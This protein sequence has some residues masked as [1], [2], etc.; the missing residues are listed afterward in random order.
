[1]LLSP[2]ALPLNNASFPGFAFAAF[3]GFLF[4]SGGA[5]FRLVSGKSGKKR[6]K[7][8]KGLDNWNKQM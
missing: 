8:Q 2:A 3:R 7:S 4:A 5:F 1:M 6:K